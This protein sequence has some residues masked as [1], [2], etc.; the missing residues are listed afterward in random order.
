[1]FS[2]QDCDIGEKDQYMLEIRNSK[3]S[4]REPAKTIIKHVKVE[5]KKM[6]IFSSTQ[7][8]AVSLLSTMTVYFSYL[9]ELRL[10]E[11]GAYFSRPASFGGTIM[12]LYVGTS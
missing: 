10:T 11:Y 7:N 8:I 3:S 9:K 12:A 1:M 4:P 2:D 5:A 6:L